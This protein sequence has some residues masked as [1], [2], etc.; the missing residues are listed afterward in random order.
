MGSKTKYAAHPNVALIMV[1]Q[2]R[3]DCGGFAG[4]RVGRGRPY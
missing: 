3:H 2:L 4:H 1:D